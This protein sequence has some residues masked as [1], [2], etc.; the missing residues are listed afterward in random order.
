VAL[1]LLYCAALG[2]FA[3]PT[4]AEPTM[5]ATETVIRL[6]VQPMAAPKPALRYLLLPEL[7]EMTPG[8][9]IPNYLR[10]LMDNEFADKEVIGASSLKLA[11]QA[12]RM[13]K[14]D[15]QILLKA[16]TDG[17]NLLIPDVQK[18]RNLAQALQGRFREEV[19]LRRFDDALVTAKTMFAMSRHMTENPTLIAD[20]VGVAI[21]TI[22]IGPLEEM[23][24][25]PGCP[26]LYWALS[27]L[28]SPMIPLD[29]GMGAERVWMV[30]ELRDLDDG[31]PMSSTQIKKVIGRV[32]ELRKLEGRPGKRA[33]GT[34]AW[35]DEH[36]KNEELVQAARRHL[37][38]YGI[39]EERVQRFP[40]DQVMLLDQKLE[41]EVRRDDL[42][43]FMNLPAWQ[44]GELAGLQKSDM[45]LGLFELFIPAVYKVR[46][47]QGR[48]DQ[49]LA[50]LRHVEALRLYAAEHGG[51]L[52]EKLAD[53]SVPLPD[54]PFTGKP[55]LYNVDGT[56]AHIRGS[57]PAGMEKS[58]VYNLHYEVTIQK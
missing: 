31:A 25:Q 55:F 27:N 32:D 6:K 37:I 47:A 2:V 20:L 40:A 22:T 56:T 46:L 29:K 30:A 48:V 7:R 16:K 58:P 45:E 39:P 8:N 1:T 49:R 3:L 28:P 35:L 53:I 5:T 50:L 24:E 54:N 43:K 17:I 26:N 12:A 11:D 33:K 10:C 13:D 9:P 38:E 44:I 42:M 34:R 18:I 15:W 19:S 36:T 4:E 51:R 21:A 57:P 52:P 23:L 14:P 41:Y